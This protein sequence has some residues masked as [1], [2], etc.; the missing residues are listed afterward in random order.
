MGSLEKVNKLKEM[1][2]QA[3]IEAEMDKQD[4]TPDAQHY[5]Q[6]D[7]LPPPFKKPKPS[8]T[9]TQVYSTMSK[10]SVA[11]EIINRHNQAKSFTVFSIAA[12]FIILVCTQFSTWAGMGAAVVAIIPPAIFFYKINEEIKTLKYQYGIM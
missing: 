2:A 7:I 9:G 11:A 8:N 5:E 1:L 3:E 6:E 10:K 4:I 12:P